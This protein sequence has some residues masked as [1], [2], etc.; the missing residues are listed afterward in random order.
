M[1]CRETERDLCMHIVAI[2]IVYTTQKHTTS[3]HCMCVN[4]QYSTDNYILRMTP[5]PY[6]YACMYLHKGVQVHQTTHR[7]QNVDVRR[8]CHSLGVGGH[9]G[10][11]LSKQ[12]TLLS[13]NTHQHMQTRQLSTTTKCKSDRKHT[14]HTCLRSPGKAWAVQPLGRRRP[15][16]AGHMTVKG[17]RHHLA[18]T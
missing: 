8:H 7:A 3:H 6:V 12:P 2:F 17:R 9:D 14:H 13:H 4:S 5:F 16:S 10:A 18:V 15:G 1:E 11:V